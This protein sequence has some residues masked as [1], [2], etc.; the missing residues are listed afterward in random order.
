M[1]KVTNRRKEER[2]GFS[3]VEVLI[4]SVILLTLV[5]IAVPKYLKA[6]TIASLA[7]VNGDL[8]DLSW[9]LF[10]YKTAVAGGG[11]GGVFP[12]AGGVSQSGPWSP[13][14]DA[15]DFGS[16]NRDNN[17]FHACSVIWM[18]GSFYGDRGDASPSSAEPVPS[19]SQHYDLRVM[20]SPVEVIT[21]FPFD[22]FKM[23][24]S[25]PI[26]LAQYDYFGLNLDSEFVLRSLG[27]DR[28]AAVG[29]GPSGFRCGCQRGLDCVGLE[30]N[31]FLAHIGFEICGE[32]EPSTL[33]EALH[34]CTAVFSPTN[35][36]G[37]SGDLFR[38]SL[39]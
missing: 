7:E 9:G 18:Q 29:C 10:A 12:P 19:Q 21:H 22:P 38:T 39:D 30:E 23:D 8:R 27:P 25:F 32:G 17:N 20:T 36:C 24:G 33:N 11:G 16:Q 15:T 37:S 1:I 3:L 31:L 5:A 13:W 34:V 35:G 2:N 28:V 14:D 6:E 4:V 26:D